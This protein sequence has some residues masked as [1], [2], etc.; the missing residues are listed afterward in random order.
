[1]KWADR[2]LEDKSRSS[3]FRIK[4]SECNS[5]T[6]CKQYLLAMKRW[7]HP[8]C[9][10]DGLLTHLCTY[11]VATILFLRQKICRNIY[12]GKSKIRFTKTHLEKYISRAHEFL[13]KMNGERDDA[14]W[15]NF[16]F[17]LLTI[18][19]YGHPM[20]HFSIEI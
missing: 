14:K 19:E 20:K 9:V 2:N 17:L 1:M 8:L 10:V 11:K 16:L 5:L 15:Q 13:L 3:K 4:S 18:T 12:I 7:N 6:L